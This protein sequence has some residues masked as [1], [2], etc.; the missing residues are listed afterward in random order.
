MAKQTRRTYTG[1]N[2]DPLKAM[3]DFRYPDLKAACIMKGMDPLD[4]VNSDHGVLGTFFIDNWNVP[5][6]RTLLEDFDIWQDGKL[7]ELGYESDDPV[8][9]F[10]QFS[11]A[12]EDGDN[13]QVKT[14][15]LK[16][17]NVPKK[18]REKK[19]RSKFG[20]FTGTKKEYT[21]T[22]ADDLFNDRGQ[23][24]T[25]KELMKKFAKK[26]VERVEKKYPDAKPKSVK[27]WMKRALEALR[28]TNGS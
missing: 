17:A 6:D 11:S 28:P 13:I 27:I 14:R 10:R 21:Y 25:N 9:Q 19:K 7:A 16:R 26:M 18:V 22:L 3:A 1:P 2:A 12:D 15:R 20:I 24:Y 8:R 5:K 4:V 23:K